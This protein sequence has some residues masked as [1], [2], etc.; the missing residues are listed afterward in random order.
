MKKIERSHISKE[1]MGCF[2]LY[3]T[4]VLTAF[5]QLAGDDKKHALN[6]SLW[7]V[8]PSLLWGWDI[9][10]SQGPASGICTSKLTDGC[11]Q[12]GTDGTSASGVQVFYCVLVLDSG[13]TIPQAV[14]VVKTKW[15][16]RES[17]V[18]SFLCNPSAKL[19]FFFFGDAATEWKT[20]L[21]ICSYISTCQV[22]LGI[23]ELSYLIPLQ[24]SLPPE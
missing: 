2:G 13:S 11:T 10:V 9:T 19:I 5:L 22:C 3:S 14:L 1:G 4:V 24:S 8:S 15:M 23:Q 20:S 12:M 16:R 6:I 21:F 7:N 18:H 17:N